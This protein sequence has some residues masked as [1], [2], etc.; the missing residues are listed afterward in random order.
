M[1]MT[2]S[3]S[4]PTDM[5]DRQYSRIAAMVSIA[6]SLITAAAA[7]TVMI[8]SRELPGGLAV[9]L[10]GWI[11][12]AAIVLA[13]GVQL[14][15]GQAWAQRFSLVYYLVVAGFAMIAAAYVLLQS[16]PA[17]WVELVKI[18]AVP[19][20]FAAA[21]LAPGLVVG[22][23][24]ALLLVMASAARSRL[25]Y[26]SVVTVTV[27]AAVTVA[28]V[29]NLTAQ[30]D[31]ARINI[32][33]SG[34]GISERTQRIL[35]NLESP[36]RLT[37]AYTS[38][39]ERQ[40]KLAREYGPRTLE[41]LQDMA[42]CS[43]K[44]EVVDA[45]S[46]RQKAEIVNRLGGKLGQEYD[47]HI[48]FLQAFKERGKD[49]AEM[50][51]RHRDQW[52]AATNAEYLNLW[53][54]PAGV[55]D[56]L[57]QGAQTLS[58]A[59][60]EVGAKLRGSGLANYADLAGT[61]KQALS[62]S[63]EALQDIAAIIR[64]L[65]GIGPLAAKNRTGA[66]AKTQEALDAAT[67]MVRVIG[68]PEKS[69]PGD[70]AGVL[71]RYI[72]AA[73][74]ASA[75]CRA[76]A[77]ALDSIAGGENARFVVSAGA[78]RHRV[79][80]AYDQPRLVQVGLGDVYRLRAALIDRTVQESQGLL[81]AAK[82]E[83][84]A[85]TIV[86]MRPMVVWLARSLQQTH[87]DAEKATA[88]LT[89][90]DA[91]SKV[92]LDRAAR[93]QL[94][95]E[96][97]KPIRA[98]LDE[99]EKLP[100]IETTSLPADLGKDNIVIVETQG[101]TEVVAFDDAWP[102]KSQ[103]PQARM[104]AG[105]VARTFNADG[106][107]GSKILSMTAKPFAVV[108]ITYYQLPR[109]MQRGSMPADIEPSQLTTLTR[110]LEQA[111]FI[112]RQ[113][114]IKD[115]RPDREKDDPETQVLIVL[116]PPP[117][118]PGPQRGP[119]MGFNPTHIR[120]VREVIDSG[121]PAVFL[122]L[123]QPPR[124][125][126]MFSPLMPSVYGWAPYLEQDWGL[127]ALT[128]HL[129]IPAV[130]DKNDP[131][132]FRISGERFNYLPLTAF[133]DHP[134]GRPLRGQRMLWRF[135]CPVRRRAQVANVTVEPLLTVPASWR[136]TWAT[137]RIREVFAQ[138]EEGSQIWPD[139]AKGDLKAPFHVAVAATRAATPGPT[140][141]PGSAP[142]SAPAEPLG[143]K[144]TRMVVLGVGQALT[145]DYLRQPVPVADAKGALTL[146]EPP[147]GNVD[148]VVNS[149]YWLIGTE[150]YIA[151]GPAA[152]QLV[153]IT[154]TARRFLAIVLVGVLPAMAIMAGVAIMAMRR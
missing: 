61:A 12:L 87:E 32:E 91:A 80:F 71:G 1:A 55:N 79:Q 82:K 101:K 121:V 56:G 58:E 72:T 118:M 53:S 98:L 120:R 109:Q 113:W 90:V 140:S 139:Y 153:V 28:V 100:E 89:K 143:P 105:D 67:R 76:T 30:K 39:D 83:Y 103:D 27:A 33:S 134:I 13:A 112:V 34:R 7:I 106:A 42:D 81:K 96:V 60:E 17:W 88:A 75:K 44:V 16:T 26:A 21:V 135:L 14:L 97:R 86:R 6:L 107:V 137:H 24:M 29:V 73:R 84:Q 142:A 119:S 110:Q 70:P 45:S 64:Q 65:A 152:T 3:E 92:I 95:A 130:P 63:D 68:T 78:W 154:D 50:L 47:K 151:A 25:R 46:D 52:K 40:K 19:E 37:C 144:P 132:R 5:L 59:A 85:E 146:T 74:E 66:L 36:V 122:T 93:D 22:C 20:H 41:L 126:S 11:G 51:R 43:D 133:A 2:P 31:H 102:I 94:F 145:D 150:N 38:A 35:S 117:D 123:F 127:E 124:R 148:L 138:F 8:A 18:A 147:Q 115:P 69:A 131:G 9:Y 4:S 141:K 128:D 116:P 108:W 57:N 77:D 99:A 114:N 62:R 48:T 104:G 125:T 54:L 15:R 49:I 111:N 129:V 136:D 10:A 149:L 23:G